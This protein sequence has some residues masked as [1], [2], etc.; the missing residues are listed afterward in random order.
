MD[1][2]GCKSAV[3]KYFGLKCDEEKR[4]VIDGHALCRQCKNKVAARNGNTS[5]LIAHLRNNHPTI[6][7]DFA[8]QKAEKAKQ[9]PSNKSAPQQISI[10]E[11]LISSQPYDQKSK[12]WME[13]TNSVTYCIAKDMLSMYSVEKPGF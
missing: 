10:T 9:H 11:A 4:P 3:W 2:P 6:Y 1:K 5:N 12:K 8:K 7:A 13:L